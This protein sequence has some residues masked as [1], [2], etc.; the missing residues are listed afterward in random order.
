LEIGIDSFAAA[1]DATSLAVEPSERVRNLVEQI[2]YADQVGL[3]SLASVS[4]T[5]GST[6][7]RLPS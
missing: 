2:Q 3:D 4:T 1:Y 6:W 7:T 5:A